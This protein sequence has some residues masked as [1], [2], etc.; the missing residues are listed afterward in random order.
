[1]NNA[2]DGIPQNSR[3]IDTLLPKTDKI[4]ILQLLELFSK[5]DQRSS[6]LKND[7]GIHCPDRCAQ[8]CA[9]AQV[10]TTAIEM[11]PLAV[12]L[13][14]TNQADTYLELIDATQ[15]SRKC[16]F[17]NQ[18]PDAPNNGR[19]AIYTLRPLI[20]RL[21]GFFTI[22]NKY[23]KYVY[24]GCKIIREKYPEAH[25]KAMS[26]IAAHTHPSLLT[27][28][29]IQIISMGCALDRKM[30]PINLAAKLALEK[31]GLEIHKRAAIKIDN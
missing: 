11:L 19:C 22:R 15:G 29:T 26:L 31:V 1:M 16:V 9:T 23:G 4:V 8:C 12:E 24:G 2:P 25:Q 30:V 10:E 27:D 21:F 13:W 28:Y 20:C 7:S 17:L 5:V 18:D 3:K 14:R 6:Q